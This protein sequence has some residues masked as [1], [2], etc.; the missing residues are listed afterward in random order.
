MSAEVKEKGPIWPSF[1]R[2][3]AQ[4]NREKTLFKNVLF[5]DVDFE[6]LFRGLWRF[7]VHFGRSQGLPKATKIQKK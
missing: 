4:T 2:V 1:W 6:M 3:A 7:G 5:S